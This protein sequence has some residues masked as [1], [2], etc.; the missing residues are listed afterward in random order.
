MSW[1]K[2]GNKPR[3]AGEYNLPL[4][5]CCG[6]AG[7][8]GLALTLSQNINTYSSAFELSGGD[9]TCADVR[10]NKPHR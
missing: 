8:Q 5:P 3:G 1:K 9:G 4:N 7:E 10:K 6:V 2:I